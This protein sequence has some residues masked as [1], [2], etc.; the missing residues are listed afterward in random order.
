M[1]ADGILNIG[2]LGAANIA[3]LFTA[4]VR[5]SPNVRIRA[6]AARDH[7]RAH[8]FAQALDIPVVHASYD[9]LLADPSIDAVY[10]PLPNNLHAEWSIRAAQA[11]KHVLCEKPLCLSSREAV[12]MFEVAEANGVYLVEGYPYRC[13]PQTIK[14]RQLLDQREIGVLQTVQASFGF[15][16]SD[17]HNIRFNAALGGG[18]LMDAGS[19][20]LSVVRMIAGERPTRVHA[21][22]VWSGTGVDRALVGSMEHASGLL[23]QISCS[24]ST[25]RHRRAVIVGD[26]GTIT[27]TYFNDTNAEMA[28]RLEVTRGIG[29]DA[30]REII[31][32]EAGAGFLA[33]AEAFARLVRNGWS[34]WPGATP[35]E[36]TDIMRTIEAMSESA[37]DG[38]AV[39]ID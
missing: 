33:E 24:F 18:A 32:T 7:D 10:N 1:T 8:A 36:S 3:K 9:D 34:A 12:S 21:F 25:A 2:I 39:S 11:H 37:R 17:P 16:L 5:A 30:P 38:R 27:T 35:K 6:V 23:A 14:L 15:S 26:R 20:P 28:P 19:Y 31:E 29:W 4:A 22:A 13:Q